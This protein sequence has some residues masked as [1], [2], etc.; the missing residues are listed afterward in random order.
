[1]IIKINKGYK[2]HIEK[3]IK[4]PMN[5][6]TLSIYFFKMKLMGI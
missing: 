4:G 6:E 2:E 5:T 3:S 1:M